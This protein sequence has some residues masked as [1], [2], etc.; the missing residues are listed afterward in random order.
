MG[1]R[2]RRRIGHDGD[3]VDRALLEEVFLDIARNG[4]QVDGT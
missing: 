4:A 3:R 2:L 1:S